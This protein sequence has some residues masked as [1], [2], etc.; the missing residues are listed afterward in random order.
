MFLRSPGCRR[1]GSIRPGGR[2]L[3]SGRKIIVQRRSSILFAL[4][5]GALLLG[6][7]REDLDADRIEIPNVRFESGVVQI[8]T[9]TDT[10]PLRV[11]IAETDQQRRVGLMRR[12]SLPEEEGMVFLFDE[13]Q[14]PEA[15]FW[16]FNT[17]IPLSIAYIG[18]DGVIGSIRQMVP[19][20]SPNPDFCPT[21][22]A[23]VPYRAALEV[24]AGFFQRRGIDVGDRVILQ[25]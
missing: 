16:M 11:D 18:G 5:G 1:S 14:P 12:P 19:C 8:A 25:R 10:I 7:D 15:G 17:L 22:A 3:S 21:Y 4:L 20:P 23:G 6:C 13:E 24:N 2:H 9:E